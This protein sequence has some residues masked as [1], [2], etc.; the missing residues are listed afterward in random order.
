M[1]DIRRL[2]KHRE[3]GISAAIIGRALYE[4]SLDLQACQQLADNQG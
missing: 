1:E 3:A 4:G 2:L